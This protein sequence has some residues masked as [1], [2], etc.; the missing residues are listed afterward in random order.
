[1]PA[2]EKGL[3]RFEK[4]F[5]RAAA[6]A[7]LRVRGE[8]AR[9]AKGARGAGHRRRRSRIHTEGKPEEFQR[10]PRRIDVAS[11]AGSSAGLARS[12]SESRGPVP[13]TCDRAFPQNTR[14][15]NNNARPSG[16]TRHARGVAD[17]A[18]SRLCAPAAVPG[19]VDRHEATRGCERAPPPEGFIRLAHAGARR[20]R[21]ED[22]A[23]VFPPEKASG[24]VTQEKDHVDPTHRHR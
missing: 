11:G 2:P 10:G 22:L 1:N 5:Q 21:V 23:T 16:P 13:V 20:P 19:L 9:A 3:T 6:V 7:R 18:R 15:S 8:G 12:R 4:R 24:G 17:A 14:N